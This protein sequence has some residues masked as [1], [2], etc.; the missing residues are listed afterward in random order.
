M[1]TVVSIVVPVHNEA[2]VL[3]MNAL[4]LREHLKERLSAH[5]IILCEN[6]SVDATPQIASDLAGEFED[7]EFLALPDRSLGEAL[8]AGV[9]MAN[10]EKVVYIPIDLAVDLD[11]IE[12]SVRLLEVFDVVIGSKRMGAG[13]DKRSIVRRVPSMAF[14]GMV[15]SLFGVEFTDSTCVKA[16]RRDSILDLMER[17]PPSSRVFETELLVEA[18]RM[19]LYVAEVPVVVGERRPSRELLGRKIRSKLEDLL[20]ARLDR[21]SLMVGV[22]MFVLGFFGV[23]FL[24]YVKTTSSVFGGFVN[25]YAFLISMLLVISGFQIMTL[26]LLSKLIMQIRRQIFGALKDRG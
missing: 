6:G 13:L 10:Y 25:P 2:G 21:I 16:Y 24:T 26:G 1:E 7:V 3:R 8:K 5:E 9:Q 17:I 14:H 12:E 11:F 15:R 18:E 4:K 19:G 23:L 22:P 20:S